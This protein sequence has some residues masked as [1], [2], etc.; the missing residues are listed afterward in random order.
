MTSDEIATAEEIA[1]YAH[2][3][4]GFAED[5]LNLTLDI[6][7]K[8][9][10]DA[11][12]EHTKVAVRSSTGQGKDFTASIAVLHFLV[13]FWKAYVPCTANS[14][15]QL[16]TILWKQ[17]SDLIGNSNGIDVVFKWEATSIKHREYGAEWLAFAKT[18]AKKISSGG[19]RSAEGSAGHHADNM[20]VLMDEASGIDEEFWQAYEPTLTGPNNRIIAI[21]NPNRLSGSFYQIWFNPRV[22]GFWKRFTI[23]G[24]S[25][26]KA[27]A[28]AAV[29]DEYHVSAR[30]NQSGN[31]DYLIA[32]WGHQ[33]PMVQSKV[34]GVHPTASSND[35]GF[36]FE[37]VKAAMVQGRLRPSDTDAVQIGVDVARFGDD[38]TAYAIRRGRKFRQIIERKQT[39]T[40]IGDM[41]I[42]LID[43]EPDPIY[44]C[45]LIVI[46]ES[47]VG[48]GVVDYVK[49]RARQ[50]GIK[51]RM[52]A[53]SF[54]GAARNQKAYRNIAAEMWLEDLKEYFTCIECGRLY[55]AHQDDSIDLEYQE[56]TGLWVPKS[57]AIVQ[58]QCRRFNPNIE[59]EDD[60][61]LLAELTGRKYGFTG[62]GD[63]NPKTKLSQRFIQ[64]KDEM[65]S[66]GKGSPDRA[67]ALCLAVVRPK[68]P[69]VA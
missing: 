37:E 59:L 69:G 65:K 60:D 16:Q 55:E 11:Y 46:D 35:T 29:G 1:S 21:G 23:A 58:A 64:P 2:D 36:S 61:E 67:D 31:H 12:L 51:L 9:F 53:V 24:K 7:Q 40:H 50:L 20:L 25:S 44:G 22:S 39:T 49:Q 42:D 43:A 33:H 47:G 3:P 8:R 14:K 4:I 30:G 52:R 68:T 17:F 32:K 15:E 28:F 45:P 13:S 10:L 56:S 27:S 34:Y 41:I 19:E 57:G 5:V 38:D 62:K 6:W 48:G 18:S 66:E 54:G 26:P 63:G